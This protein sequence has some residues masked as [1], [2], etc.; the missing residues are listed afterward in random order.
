M[1]RVGS[2]VFLSLL[3][4]ESLGDGFADLPCPFQTLGRKF[5]WVRPKRRDASTSNTPS[6]K[7]LAIESHVQDPPPLLE[8]A[9]CGGQ[10]PSST[11][12]LMRF[13]QCGIA[14]SCMSIPDCSNTG[15]G[16]QR[17]SSSEFGKLHDSDKA[18]Y[19]HKDEAHTHTHTHTYIYI[20]KH[21]HIH[22][23]TTAHTSQLAVLPTLTEHKSCHARMLQHIIFSTTAW[24]QVRSPL[25]DTTPKCYVVASMD[26]Q[27]NRRA[28]ACC[29]TEPFGGL[30]LRVYCGN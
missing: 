26:G 2:L 29:I 4:W 10:Q 22:A 25:Q 19:K 14:W 17:M 12:R 11:S 24:Q 8:A 6:K 15:K 28:A 3:S 7:H 13:R 23:Q 5:P 27:R 9:A 1:V 16:S 20:Y 30:L 21:T 18:P